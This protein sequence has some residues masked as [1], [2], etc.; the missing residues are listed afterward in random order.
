MS[1]PHKRIEKWFKAETLPLA[2][3]LFTT[4][5]P[6]AGR[7][8]STPTRILV[9]R[10]DD[11][12][13]NLLLM[14]PFL[15]RL[16]ETHPAARIGMVVGSIYAPLLRHWPW[17]DRWI[18][19]E[20]RAHIRAPW[21]FTAW[22][23]EIR[24]GEWDLAF[25]MSNHNTHSYYSCLLTLASGA[26]A[27]VGF[28]EPR[29]RDTLTLAVPAPGATRHFSLSPLSLLHALGVDAAEAAIECPLPS[30]GDP[31]PIAAGEPYVVVHVG[32]RGGKALPA[33][34]WHAIVT[35]ALDTVRGRVIVIA[36]P[37]ETDRIP[38]FT[39]DRGERVVLAPPLDVLA[40]A[41]LLAGARA[42]VGCDSGV[43]HL[44][45]AVGTPAVAVFFRSNPYHYAPLGAGHTTV[46]L[47]NPY[48]VTRDAW[49]TPDGRIARSRL[50]EVV[51]DER[52]SIEGRPSLG[53]RAVDAIVTSVAEATGST[54][55]TLVGRR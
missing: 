55:T 34:T 41:R 26:P 17:V 11:R 31:A 32:G 48:G 3:R 12:L 18:V 46:L 16:R 39:G 44:A 10:P 54:T 22:L 50:V 53:D 14:T 19:Q 27:R 40:L 33:S 47:A 52:A 37:A 35:R 4:R 5:G 51:T 30:G 29:N 45:V 1:A 21:K 9:V 36:G 13:G 42:Y 24:D 28:D 23:G 49:E 43:L 7:P 25:E 15:R 6:A 38:T 2:R 8:G 20:K